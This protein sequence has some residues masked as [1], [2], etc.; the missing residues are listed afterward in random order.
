M[1]YKG[2]VFGVIDDDTYTI[3][4]ICNDIE[5]NMK[6]YGYEVNIFKNGLT[7]TIHLK[8]EKNCNWIHNTSTSYDSD[9]IPKDI[10]SFRIVLVEVS[11][12]LIFFERNGNINRFCNLIKKYN[13]I[14]FDKVLWKKTID[15]DD[16]SNNSI[17]DR[18]KRYYYTFEKDNL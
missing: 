2:L 13:P 4:D 3:Y 18:V 6:L 16:C 12:T 5:R 8:R 9:I 1:S 7:F 15:T 14:Y 10:K 11:D 17:T